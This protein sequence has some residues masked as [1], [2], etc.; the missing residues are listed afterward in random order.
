MSGSVWALILFAC[1]YLGLECFAMLT[2]P[3]RYERAQ[4]AAYSVVVLSS[5]LWL[6][7]L[8]VYGAVELVRP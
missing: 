6:I 2:L 7:G 5:F 4:L 1:V 3:A 8:A